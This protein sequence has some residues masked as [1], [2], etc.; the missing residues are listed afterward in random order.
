MGEETM[1]TYW[2]SFTLDSRTVNGEDYEHRWNALYEA[3]R[4]MST[5]WWF[6]TTAF[7]VFE[8]AETLADVTTAVMAAVSPTYDLVLIRRMDHQTANIF[9]PIGDKSIFDMM[10]YLKEV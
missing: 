9:G 8:T 10:P 4:N 7:A 6:D 1:A 5:N 2:L 3:I